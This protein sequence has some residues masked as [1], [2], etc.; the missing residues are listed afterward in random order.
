MNGIFRP[1]CDRSAS[2][3]PPLDRELSLV[4]DLK[5]E[6]PPAIALRGHGKEMDS[7]FGLCLSLLSHKE[8]SGLTL[9]GTIAAPTHMKSVLCREVVIKPVEEK[10]L[11][12]NIY[13]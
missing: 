4:R 7:P 11:E 6:K 5:Q 8:H 12:K 10:N 2:S 1:P 13:L 3:I 9:Q